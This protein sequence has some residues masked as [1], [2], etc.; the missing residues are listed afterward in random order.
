MPLGSALSTALSGLNANQSALDVIG[1][2]LANTNTTSFKAFRNEFVNNFY[3][4]LGLG[5]APGTA[6][7]GTNPRQIGQGA[8]VGSLSTDFRPG[9][10]NQTGVPSDLYI[11]GNGFFSVARGAEIVYTRDGSFRLNSR[12]ELVTAQ[13]FNVQGFGI[14]DN[15]NIQQGALVNLTIPLGSLQVAQET[16]NA[17]LEGS[18]NPQGVAATQATIVQSD[19]MTLLDGVT[20]ATGATTL[21]NILVNGTTAMVPGGFPATLTYTPVKGNRILP[22]ES[23]T[24]TAGTT[25]QE[26]GDFI[27]GSLGINTGITQPAGNTPGFSISAGGVASITG[28]LGELSNFQI[29]GGDF[30]VSGGGIINL[31]F[32]N[33]AQTA[34]GESVFTQFS[35]FDSLGSAVRVNITGYLE[36][37]GTEFST[38]RF[39]FDSPD[40]SIDPSL[41]GNF[42][43]SIGSAVLTFD[44]RGQLQTVIGNQLTVQRDL[45]GAGDPLTFILDVDGVSALS[46]PTSQ[47]A[48]VSQDGSPPG[49]LIDF[50]ID[51]SGVIVGAFDNGVTRNL[52][53]IALARFS[54]P[55]GLVAQ[56]GNL[57]RQGPNS[58]LPFTTTPGQG[59]GTILSGALELGNVD[60][61]VSFVQLLTA[62]TAFSANSRVIAT[63]QDLFQTLLQL[64]RT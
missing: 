37:L 4:T 17:F 41:A 55:Q 34:N 64:P 26:L 12:S 18:L 3:N 5:S 20:P 31:D 24:L 38:F 25:L 44:Q 29:D 23:L 32:P 39:L 48:V 35:A 15:F 42:D 40:Q 62:S 21:G 27:V 2:N 7:A 9:S 11:Q 60:V 19:P 43:N 52:G 54:N 61:A 57:Y 10:P 56:D 22:P 33:R 47:L 13:G 8:N 53:Q 14:D 51:A 46:V 45:T 50:G 30:S 6:N 28:N 59:V 49:T 1:N 16:S 63:T 58:G 36:Q